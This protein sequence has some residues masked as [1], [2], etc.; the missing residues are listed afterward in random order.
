MGVKVSVEP[1]EKT[2]ELSYVRKIHKYWARKPF[3]NISS[4]IH[5]FSKKGD[6][7]LDPFCGSGTMGLASISIDRNFIGYDLNGTAAFISKCTLESGIDIKALTEEAKKIKKTV[8][9]EYGKYYELKNGKYVVYRII[10]D[11]NKNDYNASVSDNI[12]C[13]GP[14]IKIQ[15][16]EEPYKLSVPQQTFSYPDANFPKK[17]YKDRFSY[18]GVSKVSD[19]FT[20]RNLYVLSGI[21]NT[22]NNSELKYA[23]YFRLALSNTI[24]HCSKLKSENV[25]PMSVNNYWI[26]DAYIEE[27][28]VY[29]FIDRLNNVLSAKKQISKQLNGKKNTFTIYNES[30]LDLNKIENDSID[31]VITDPPYG[32]AIQ[33]SEL[34][35]IWNC[36]LGNE[37]TPENEVI[38]NPSQNKGADYFYTMIE[39]SIESISKKLKADHYFTICFQNKDPKIWDRLMKIILDHGFTLHS[40]KICDTLGNSYNK[41][42]AKFSPKSDLYV[43]FINS[44]AKLDKKSLA[45]EISADDIYAK[46]SKKNI[47]S[48]NDFYNHFVSTLLIEL[49]N[50]K[51]VKDIEKL[52]LEKVVSY[53]GK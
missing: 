46:L 18:K 4:S 27:N 25:R 52:S 34:S 11:N 33:Y 2:P 31:Y 17:F 6:Y 53:Y 8:I 16:E 20:K 3:S 36:W 24:L 23:D 32:E 48:V 44:R 19:F 45:E 7:V 37:K 29:R 38:I 13:L 5:Q 30:S 10:G 26:P 42:W 47:E 39:K 14:K 12:N 22:I 21:L 28:A 43:T 41:N 9:E 49:S 15:I 50:R 1:I 51:K 35:F 40:I